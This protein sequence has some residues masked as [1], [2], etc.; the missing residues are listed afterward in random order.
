MK[1]EQ[2]GNLNRIL[3]RR[4]GTDSF[5]ILFECYG[6]ADSNTLEYKPLDLR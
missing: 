4:G 6:G 5:S 1:T 2:I 3:K